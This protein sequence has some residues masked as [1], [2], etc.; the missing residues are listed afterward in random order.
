M[1]G[2]WFQAVA[3]GFAVL[4]AGSLGSTCARAMGDEPAT[5]GETVTQYLTPAI[6]EM[7]FPG[8]EK[9]GEVGG[10]PPSAALYKGGRQ[11]GYLFS[12]W[13]VTQSKGFSDQPLVLLVGL[14]LGGRITGARIVH[15][16]EPIAILGLHD[17]EFQRFAENYKGLDVRTGVDVVIKL[18]SSVLGQESFSQRAAPGTTNSA[19]IDA[20]SRAT[21]SS[22]LMSDAIVRGARIIGRS[23]GILPSVGTSAAHLDLDRFAP[24]DWPEL[25]AAG[26]IAHLRILS[27]DATDKLGDRSRPPAYA[28]GPEPAPFSPSPGSRLRPHG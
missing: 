11:V 27:R 14:D 13:D 9:A 24:A 23:R 21:T 22:V 1:T 6:L 18:S 12:T 15:H 26:A 4:L 5:G 25:E 10:V 7:I 17:D 19:K 28:R 16:S 20:V 8:A 3:L 2:N